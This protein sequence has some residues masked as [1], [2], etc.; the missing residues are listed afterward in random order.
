MLFLLI[1]F[2]GML[3]YFFFF[4]VVGGPRGL[5]FYL[6]P[7]TSR[8][9]ISGQLNEAGVIPFQKLFNFCILLHYQTPLKTGEYFFKSNASYSTICN[10]ITAG[11]GLY[12]RSF[13]IIPGWTFAQI[14]KSL[15]ETPAIK[16]LVP[17]MTD[18]SV[19]T[20]MGQKNLSPEGEFYPETY[21]YTRDTQ[22][23]VILK[24]AYDLMQNRLGEAWRHRNPTVP[25]TSSYQALIAA[26]LIE[27][28]GYLDIERPLIS[29]V[30]VN[31]LK[32]NMLLQIDASVIY[33]LGSHYTGKITK[34]DLKLNTPYNT[35]LHVGLPPTPIAVPSSASLD[36]AMQPAAHDFLYYVAKGDGSHQFSTNFKAHETAIQT[37]KINT[38]KTDKKS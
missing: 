15:A 18:E 2:F 11:T 6:K 22:D 10:Q 35:Y 19:M 7:G 36:A 23:L 13:T 14:K 37:T 3:T 1:S 16:H 12:Y 9:V 32:K 4:P 20:L 28:E 38:K 30:I 33:G 26:S 21:R 34:E 24:Q 27:R 29:G 5:V 17:N 31:R 25:Y 8:H